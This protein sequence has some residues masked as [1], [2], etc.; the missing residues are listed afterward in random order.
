MTERLVVEAPDQDSAIA[1]V[2]EF[3]DIQAELA[4]GEGARWEVRVELRDDRERQ[5][6]AA[7]EAVER[8]LTSSGIEAAKVKVGGQTHVVQPRATSSAAAA[9]RADQV[10]KN[11]VRFREVNERISQAAEDAAFAGPMVFVCECGDA[12]C[13]ETIQVT[14]AE[15]EG[16]RSQPTV[17]LIVAGHEINEFERVV[18]Q[19][20][21]FAAVA[22][23]GEGEAIAYRHDPRAS[24]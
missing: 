21:R 2:D 3:K 1:L 24:P 20:D 6:E 10:A 15:Y 14:L 12:E 4:P 11:E 9:G 18:E 16:A 19:N 17:F 13:S 5:L 7:L 22:K 23:V 8:W